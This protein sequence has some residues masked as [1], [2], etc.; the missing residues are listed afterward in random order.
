MKIGGAHHP[1]RGYLIVRTALSYNN[2]ERA[3]RKG[4]LPSKAVAES[5]DF[6]TRSRH[7]R[8]GLGSDD[9]QG[10]RKRMTIAFE[11]DNPEWTLVARGDLISHGILDSVA[12]NPRPRLT[13]ISIV[14][15]FALGIVFDYQLTWWPQLAPLSVTLTALFA[16]F[17]TAIIAL[18]T[19]DY[20]NERGQDRAWVRD[21]TL[22][23]LRP[24]YEEIVANVGSFSEF[25]AGETFAWDDLQ[26]QSR[27]IYVPQSV[28]PGLQSYYGQVRSH[29][30]THARAWNVVNER[31]RT[32]FEV[33]FK[34]MLKDADHTEIAKL[35][36]GCWSQIVDG[37]LDVLLLQ[38]DMDRYMIMYEEVAGGAKVRSA[39]VVL[40]DLKTAISK[41]EKVTTL[42]VGSRTRLDD[43]NTML[44]A[45]RPVLLRPWDF[46]PKELG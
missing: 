42:Q 32:S 33:E 25:R 41:E 35:V 14:V 27:R 11:Y 6:G 23:A 10:S 24:V 34:S 13:A 29:Q 37:N 2:L 36:M 15:L 12:T 45:L 9:L 3:E 40:R 7:A 19:V 44:V 39:E 1:P 31:V 16:V 4:T 8:R 5:P 46:P 43:S 17:V 18:Y 20:L 22:N 26:K 28:E 21:E 30:G 38:R